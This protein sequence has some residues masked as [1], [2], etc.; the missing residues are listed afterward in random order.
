VRC[1]CPRYSFGSPFKFDDSQVH[2]VFVHHRHHQGESQTQ[3][4]PSTLYVL[5]LVAV[6]IHL[7]KLR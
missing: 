5:R 4:I 7:R 6:Q 2:E 1:N 3:T